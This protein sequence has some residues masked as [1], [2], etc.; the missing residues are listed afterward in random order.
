M[1]TLLWF[2]GRDFRL[3]DQPALAAAVETEALIPVVVLDPRRNEM[4]FRGT[5][6]DASLS[7]LG[8]GLRPRGSRLI[9]WRDAESLVM[10]AVQRWGVDR[11]AHRFRLHIGD[12][13]SIQGAARTRSGT[14]LAVF[15]PFARAFAH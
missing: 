11:V 4:P 2:R 13:L 10:Y 7:C 5:F 8:V 1:R 9:G 3:E 6:Q 15:T 14:H 12:T